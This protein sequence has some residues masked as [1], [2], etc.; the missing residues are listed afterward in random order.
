MSSF[1]CARA[2]LSFASCQ[3]WRMQCGPRGVSEGA[4]AVV[5]AL[6]R[7]TASGARDRNDS[8]GTAGCE[9]CALAAPVAT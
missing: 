3:K 4:W 1:V 9:R 5:V 2:A 6:I 7:G 8:P